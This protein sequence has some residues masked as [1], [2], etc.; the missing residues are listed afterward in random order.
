MTEEDL[1]SGRDKD[2]AERLKTERQGGQL[3]HHSP[4]GWKG[5]NSKQ[6]ENVYPT[7]GGSLFH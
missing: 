5:W 2:H 7:L 6:R 4:W 3:V 1:L